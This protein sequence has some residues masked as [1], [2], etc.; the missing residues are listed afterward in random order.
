MQRRNPGHDRSSLRDDGR[1]I[2]TAQ[3]QLN[4]LRSGQITL[5]SRS[6]VNGSDDESVSRRSKGK[7]HRR[8]AQYTIRCGDTLVPIAKHFR[9]EKD[10]LLRG[11]GCRRTPSN[12]GQL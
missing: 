10:D 2:E 11:T 5:S 6:T 12:L 1:R 4:E 9:V 8:L 3:K 7:K